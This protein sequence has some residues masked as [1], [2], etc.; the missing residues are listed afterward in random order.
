MKIRMSD[1]EI[2]EVGYHT[3]LHMISLGHAEQ[4]TEKAKPKPEAKA[5]AA[6]AKRSD[7][8]QS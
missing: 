4:V 2:G 6:D 3:G 8:D 5:K 1:G 7:T